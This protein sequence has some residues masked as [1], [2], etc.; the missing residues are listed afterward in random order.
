M[1]DAA[2]GMRAAELE[3][4]LPAPATGDEL[5][6]LGQAFNGLL[7]RVQE[8]FQ[9]QKRFTG[10]ASHQLRTPLTVMHGQVEVALRRDRTPQEYRQALESV[11]V[12]SDRLRQ[13]IE[14][15]LFLSRADSESK[16]PHLETIDLGE[17]LEKHL[18]QW[19]AHARRRDIYTRIE[20]DRALRIQTH[21]PL[22]GQLIDNLLDNACKYSEAGTHVTIRAEEAAGCCRVSIEDAGCGIPAEESSHIFEPFYRSS[23]ARRNGHEGVG[24]G[25][26]VAQRIARAFGG[27]ISVASEVARG[28]RFIVQLPR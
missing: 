28:S 4:R 11:A 24:L 13:I 17:W 23:A 19:S 3:I 20:G 14:M 15:L 8:S 18:E 12:Q 10:D 9:R 7:D 2:R 21:P 16:L 5:E 6:N 27:N 26:A 1:A 22:L 25:L